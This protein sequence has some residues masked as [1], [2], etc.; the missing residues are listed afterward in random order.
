MK[1]IP[2]IMKATCKN[3]QAPGPNPQDHV[4]CFL[5]F[6]TERG[7]CPWL[8]FFTIILILSNL[9][10]CQSLSQ[11]LETLDDLPQVIGDEPQAMDDQ[12]PTVEYQL[13][14]VGEW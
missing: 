8:L 12:P 13:L 3:N 11:D 9:I 5:N 1:R 6:H 7:W 10:G 2:V 14:A 4:V